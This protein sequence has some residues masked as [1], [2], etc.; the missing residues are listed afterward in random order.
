MLTYKKTLLLFAA[1]LSL[2][3]CSGKL[4]EPQPDTSIDL[5]R[6]QPQELPLLLQG[7]YKP[8]GVYYQSYPVW[9]IYSDDIVSIQGGTPSQFNPAG[10]DACNPTVEDGFGNNR[11]IASAYKSIGN[12]NIIINYIRSKKLS[13]QSQVLGEALALRAFQY[14]RLVETYGGV[15]LTLDTET[16]INKIRRD[17]NTEAEVYA[18]IVADLTEAIPLLKDFTTPNAA[19]RQTAQL[20]LARVYLQ[21]GKSQEAGDLAAAVIRSG[22]FSLVSSNYGQIFQFASPAKEMMWRGVDGPLSAN[23]NRYGLYSFYSPGAPFKGNSPGLTWM[24]NDLVALYEPADIRRQLLHRQRN[25]ATGQEVTYLLKFSVDTLQSTS[26]SYAIY[27]YIRYSEAFLIAAEASAR[28]GVV[29]V[30]YYNQLRTARKASTKSNG[31]FAGAAAFLKELEN[32]RRREFAGEGRRW[33]DMRRFGTA[34]PFLATKGK[35]ATR[36]YL[37]F[38]SIDIARNPKLTQNKGY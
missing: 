18:A 9:D 16:D 26:A 19:C 1:A 20:L 11:T 31:D 5:D 15:I 8:D 21:L 33:Q 23:F 17:K 22:K 4:D 32:E 12:A 27:P 28:K 38:N 3:G 14:S 13:D 36:L 2:A 37:P 29:D 30:T 7:A 24:S 6:L 34:I 25:A 35:D 10:Y